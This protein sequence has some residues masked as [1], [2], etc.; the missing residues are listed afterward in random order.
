MNSPKAE[1]LQQAVKAARAAFMDA[2]EQY[3]KALMVAFDTGFRHPDGTHGLNI[4]ARRSATALAGV[5]I[6]SQ[7]MGGLH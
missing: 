3:H 2:G 1:A 7:A 6:G 5:P 4:A